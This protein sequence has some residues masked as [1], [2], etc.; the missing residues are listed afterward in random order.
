L[1]LTL[2]TGTTQ[3]TRSRSNDFKLLINDLHLDYAKYIDDITIAYM[4]TGP[5]DQSLQFATDRLSAW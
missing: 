4:S 2:L 5:N 1:L 3:G